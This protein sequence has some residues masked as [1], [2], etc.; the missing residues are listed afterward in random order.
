MKLHICKLNLS[1]WS[2]P[3]DGYSK[4]LQFSGCLV[5]GKVHSRSLGYIESIRAK[6]II[7]VLSKK[8]SIEEE[9]F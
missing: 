6:A 8:E 5:C 2:A 3:V 1:K 7:T 9:H 4:A